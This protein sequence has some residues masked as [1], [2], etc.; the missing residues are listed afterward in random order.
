M[1]TAIGIQLIAQ[2]FKDTWVFNVSWILSIVITFLV[3][4]MI[5]RDTNEWK[6]L[7]FPV[8]LLL[9]I[10]G[11]APNFI[12]YLISAIIFVVEML[13]FEAA[14]TLLQ[15]AGIK[16]K[17]AVGPTKTQKIKSRAIERQKLNLFKKSLKSMDRQELDE[18]MGDI[19][20][21]K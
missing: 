18:L 16:A 9:H 1:T 3:M 21:G 4:V 12:I 8:M 2:I 14:G 5:T 10:M 17:Q 6:K 7:A 11:L 13:S 19:K 20:R 15:I